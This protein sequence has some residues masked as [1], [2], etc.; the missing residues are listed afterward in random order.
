MA[1]IALAMSVTALPVTLRILVDLEVMKTKTAVTITSAAL[2]TDA[3]LMLGLSLVLGSN[4]DSLTAVDVILLS[5]GFVLFFVVALLIG[6]YI[7]PFV[8]RLLRWMRTGEAAFAVAKG[9]AYAGCKSSAR[10]VFSVG[11]IAA[12]YAFRRPIVRGPSS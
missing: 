3:A 5:S 2:I 9:P 11:H 8:Y 1:F 10:I 7:V 4:S 6:K 12:A